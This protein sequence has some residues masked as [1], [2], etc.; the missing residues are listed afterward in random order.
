MRA[1]SDWMG[2]ER[3]AAA[4]RVL[5]TLGLVLIVALVLA[6]PDAAVAGPGGVFVKSMFKST[7][8]KIIGGIVIGVLCLV[9]LPLILW[10]MVGERRGISR[11]RTALT[12][13]AAEDERF[14]WD[15]ISMRV[16]EM[17]PR[18]YQAWSAG[19]L[20]PVREDLFSDYYEVQQETLERWT[21]EGK[22]N[23]CQLEQVNRI[24][25]LHI[26]TSGF[27]PVL[28]VKI[29]IRGVDFLESIA[30]G[31]VLKG[32]RSMD[33]IDTVWTLVH[34]LRSWKLAEIREGDDTLML[35]K[36]KD[37]VDGP[38]LRPF[39][40]FGAGASGAAAAELAEHEPAGEV[41]TGGVEVA[42]RDQR[43]S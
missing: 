1:V 34:D 19:D 7:A 28:Y 5:S 21:A 20:S 25:P 40:A 33:E 16:R 4:T 26:D 22:R 31:K 9:L 32:K 12:A 23:I 10:V 8:G 37:V 13:L 41:E 18:V 11:C 15:A 14:D 3:A 24:Q 39:E 29:A 38:A 36:E 17:L 27:L 2:S 42:E 6:E 35:A 43:D 30:E